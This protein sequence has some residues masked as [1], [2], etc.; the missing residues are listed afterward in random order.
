MEIANNLIE[1]NTLL[2]PHADKT[3]AVTPMRSDK[4]AE[5]IHPGIE[6]MVNKCLAL[7]DIVVMQYSPL[8]PLV[9][10]LYGGTHNALIMDKNEMANYWKS[11]SV[12]PDIL[13]FVSVEDYVAEH[14]KE[15]TIKDVLDIIDQIWIDEGWVVYEHQINVSKLFQSFLWLNRK[16]D[17]NNRLWKQ[18]VIVNCN[19]DGYYKYISEQFS[20]KYCGCDYVVIDPVMTP[21]G[22]PYSQHQFYACSPQEVADLKEATNM[23]SEVAIENLVEEAEKTTT[24]NFRVDYLSA[25]LVDERI[26]VEMRVKITGEGK[27]RGPILLTGWK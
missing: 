2:L 21:E 13:Y 20:K 9:K 4:E 19:K 11:A 16:I 26:F 14:L 25:H 24:T 10:L 18:D 12:A 6:S 27:E 15:L 8:E 22:V 1:L 5:P 7:G 3:I 23:I 17:G